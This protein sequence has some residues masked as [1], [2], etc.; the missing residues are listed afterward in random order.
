MK[1]FYEEH[2]HGAAWTCPSDGMWGGWDGRGVMGDHHW[3]ASHMWGTGYGAEWM[4]SHAAG[5][6]EWL[7]AS[8]ASRPPTRPRGCRSTR[9][10]CAAPARRLL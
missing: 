6:G 10:L 1:A 7:E 5:L 3:D 2:G 4:M 9:V 8:A